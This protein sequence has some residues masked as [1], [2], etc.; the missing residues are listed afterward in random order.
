MLSIAAT[1]SKMPKTRQAARTL[2][3]QQGT[4]DAIDRDPMST[5]QPT[6]G[7][8]DRPCID[9]LAEPVA[10]RH[11]PVVS[12]PRAF[13]LVA[14]VFA[15]IMLGTTLPTPL[16]VLYQAQ[17]HFSSGIITVIFASYAA[18]V[19]AALLLAGRFSDQVGR[20]PVLAA[21]LTFSAA[22]TV[23]FI[24][25]PSLGW[26]FVGRVLSG[27]SAGLVTGTATAALT[28]LIGA[29]SSRRASLVATAV[30]MGGL[31]LGPVVA[32]LFAQY[33][34]NPT[35]LVFELYLVVLAG[36]AVALALVV[37]TVTDRQPLTFRF[38]G[39]GIPTAGRGEFIA[40]GVAGFSAFSLLGLF[41]A[42]APTFL[43][44]VLH[45]HSHAVAGAV[46]F[47]IFAS[48]TLTQLALA[49]FA[50]RPV[51]LSGLG[52][53]PVALAL[54]VSALSQA[55]MALF[56]VGTVLGGVAAGAVFIASLS[57]ANRLASAQ[58]RGRVVST[59]FVFAYVGLTVPVIGVGIASE[60]VGDFRA[61]L[62]CSV[63]LAL[64]CA[65]SMVGIR[66]GRALTL[67]QG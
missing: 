20:R 30:N 10:I 49:R 11:G 26:L 45:Q 13:W 35:V 16:Y 61:V 40:A 52:L 3:L 33:D 57:T 58:T 51:A 37:E 8:A 46:V 53:F 14:Y 19:L 65:F 31:G 47:V 56:L 48:A 7:T 42:L 15:A 39:L 34:P 18:G 9:C 1:I 4:V 54:I 2:E 36:A 59:F 29:S 50:S 21:G 60:H 38:T 62:V 32:G 67:V 66:R 6:A 24:L 55:S 12:R 43:S 41:T 44:G 25:A 5:P 63:V 23:V 27:L 28:D 22:S 17:W 64:L